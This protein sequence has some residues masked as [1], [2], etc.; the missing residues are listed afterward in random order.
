VKIKYKNINGTLLPIYDLFPFSSCPTVRGKA[1][2]AEQVDGTV[3]VNGNTRPTKDV[4][5]RA[6]KFRDSQQIGLVCT[7][8]V[9]KVAA[10]CAAVGTGLSFFYKTHVLPENKYLTHKQQYY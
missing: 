6:F 2:T 4:T 3:D 1:T 7:A 10:D 8:K 9:C 5:I